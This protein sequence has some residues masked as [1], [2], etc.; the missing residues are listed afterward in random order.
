MSD[1]HSIND[2]INR[3]AGRKLF[4]SIAIAILLLALIFSSMAFFTPGFALLVTVAIAISV[5]ELVRALKKSGIDLRS[6]TLIA[7]S[8]ALLATAWFEGERGVLIALPIIAIANLALLLSKG[9]EDFI[10]RSSATIFIL[11]YLGVFPAFILILASDSD[12]FALISLL[13]ILVG[14]NDT[15]AYIFGVLFGKHK[16]APRLSPKKSWEGFAGGFIATAIGASLG[17]HYLLEKSWWLGCGVA[18]L[19]VAAATIGDLIESA[20]K[21]DLGI[22]DMSSLLPGHGGMLDRLDSAIITAPLLWVFLEL[23]K[24]LS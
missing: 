23:T 16:M 11:F 15:F 3:R 19:G 22:K 4:S 12:G 1:L 9:P 7:S 13:V 18:L 6:K 5:D 8:V 21:R 10:R 2:A 24:N 17:F 20:L 14:A